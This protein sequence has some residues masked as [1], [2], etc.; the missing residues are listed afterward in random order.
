MFR[1]LAKATMPFTIVVGMRDPLAL[2]G[3]LMI[4]IYKI[5]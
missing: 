1:S 2:L 5:C 3:W 4:I